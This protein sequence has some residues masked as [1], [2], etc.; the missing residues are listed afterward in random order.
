MTASPDRGRPI[1]ILAC[2]RSG[3]TLLGLMLQAHPRIAIPPEN[4]FLLR[5]YFGRRGFGDLGEQQNR[6][7]LARDITT[8]PRFEELGLDRA[9]V[10]DRIVA[11]GRTVGTAIGLVLR[12]YADRFGKVRWGDKRPAYRNNIWAIRRLFPDAQFVHLVRDGRDCVASLQRM[13]DWGKETAHRRVQVWMEAMENARA[14]CQEL[15]ADSFHELR[16]EDLVREPSATLTRLCAFLGEEFDAAMVRPEEVAD[17]IVPE[18]KTWHDNTRHGISA[19]SVGSFRDRLGGR[20]LRLCEAVMR[21]RLT[22]LGYE[23][24]GA[25]PPPARDLRRYR[26]VAARQRSRIQR[27]RAEDEARDDRDP[28]ADTG[29]EAGVR[30]SP[31][32]V[33]GPDLVAGR[34]L[35]W[36]RPVARKARGALV[37]R[38]R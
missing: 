2:P 6:Q 15:P 36:A 16:Y 23:L 8:A 5:T 10:S 11:D 20:D 29:V 30:P 18:R 28:V 21:D 33:P 19:R 12:A 27:V 25:P 3:T 9:A 37:R 24:T 22:D 4:R 31:D 38:G 7:R 13:P 32:P 17:Q 26:R 1:F 14:G 35:R 34:P